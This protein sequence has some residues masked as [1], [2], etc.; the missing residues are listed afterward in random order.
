[1]CS[2]TDDH[3]L[4]SVQRCDGKLH[5]AHDTRTSYS[6]HC[7]VCPIPSKQID[8]VDHFPLG[9]GD[10][11]LSDFA[12]GAERVAGHWTPR[13]LQKCNERLGAAA[14]VAYVRLPDVRVDGVGVEE[15]LA[16]HDPPPSILLR[17][18]QQNDHQQRDQHGDASRIEELPTLVLHFPPEPAKRVGA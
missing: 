3:R 4:H 9:V 10:R 7:R 17:N 1:M 12:V 15:P 13:V 2:P 5:R 11:D 16:R 6:V 18:Q 8:H 14:D